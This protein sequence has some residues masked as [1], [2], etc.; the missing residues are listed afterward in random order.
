MTLTPVAERLAIELS[1]FGFYDL[2]MSRQGFK[3][4]NSRIRGE[5]SEHRGGLCPSLLI[6]NAK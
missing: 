2:G 1:L 6:R 3:H 4:P 5:H